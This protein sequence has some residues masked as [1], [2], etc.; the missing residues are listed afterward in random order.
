[1]VT[2]FEMQQNPLFQVWKQTNGPVRRELWNQ[3]TGQNLRSDVDYNPHASSGTP[4]HEYGGGPRGFGPHAD[5]LYF[6]Q[7]RATGSGVSQKLSQD[8]VE[9]LNKA[10]H[11]SEGTVPTSAEMGLASQ[12][13]MHV[14]YTP[15]ASDPWHRMTQEGNPPNNMGDDKMNMSESTNILLERILSIYRDMSD[16]FITTD[17]AY[18]IIKMQV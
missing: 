10:F 7:Y 8:V 3:I 14:E 5:P 15:G 12:H 11:G 9:Q 18:G 1:M 17:N 6:S 13:G 16:H 2:W 4:S